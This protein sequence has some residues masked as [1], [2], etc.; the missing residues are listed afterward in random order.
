MTQKQ[1]LLDLFKKGETLNLMTAFKKTG[2]FKLSTRCSEFIQQGYKFKKEKVNF[3]TKYY[4][5]GY[6]FNYTLDLKKTPKRLLK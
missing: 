3:T 1:A 4:T 5:K 2:T 6:Y